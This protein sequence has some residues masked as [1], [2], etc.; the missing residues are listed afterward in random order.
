MLTGA[1][2]RL[3]LPSQRN[4]SRVGCSGV[5]MLSKHSL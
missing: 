2:L 3:G 4:S 5:L 1:D